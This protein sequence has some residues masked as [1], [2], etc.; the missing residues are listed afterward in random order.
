MDHLRDL[1]RLQYVDLRRA[2]LESFSWRRRS[3][4]TMPCH[5]CA[6]TPYR[7]SREGAERTDRSNWLRVTDCIS[8]NLP[9]PAFWQACCT[10]LYITLLYTFCWVLNSICTA[11]RCASAVY[12]GFVSLSVC[13][14]IPTGTLACFYVWRVCIFCVCIVCMCHYIICIFGLCW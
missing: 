2:D 7:T 14:T 12:A 13:P 9:L 5:R 3:P 10:A 6:G 11:R 4:G 8:V 1:V